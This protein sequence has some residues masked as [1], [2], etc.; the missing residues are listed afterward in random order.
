MSKTAKKIIVAI[1]CAVIVVGVGASF[2]VSK[3][4]EKAIEWLKIIKTALIFV[5]D[6][7]EDLKKE[8]SVK[9]VENTQ[10]DYD[11]SNTFEN[12]WD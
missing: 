10:E 3:S 4:K 7:A 2:A 12:F 6:N 11:I 5:D 9:E 1:I 8:S